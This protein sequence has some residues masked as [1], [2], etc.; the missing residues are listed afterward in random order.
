MFYVMDAVEGLLFIA[1]ALKLNAKIEHDYDARPTDVVL[2]K[3]TS[4]ISI[5]FFTNVFVYALFYANELSYYDIF[6]QEDLNG[7]SQMIGNS[8]VLLL[9]TSQM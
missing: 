3:I 4:P 9:L 2:K 5:F 6:A 1:F 7:A 8:K